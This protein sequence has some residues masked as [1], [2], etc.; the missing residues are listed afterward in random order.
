MRVQ[1]AGRHVETF[2]SRQRGTRRGKRR[3]A[4]NPAGQ[5]KASATEG[6]GTCA[7]AV[8]AHQTI[9]ANTFDFYACADAALQ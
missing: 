9:P 5:G 8:A 2:S 6:A 3:P 4:N 7:C 1:L